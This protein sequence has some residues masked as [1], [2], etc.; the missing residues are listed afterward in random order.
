MTR[1]KHPFAYAVLSILLAGIWL[2]PVCFSQNYPAHPIQLV[3]PNVAGA[4]MDIAARLLAAEME[5]I[6]GTK[7]IPNN[8]PGAATVLGTDAVVRAKKDGYT[9]LFV[10]TSALVHAP[11]LNPEVVKYDPSK[12]LEPLGLYYFFPN[13]ITVKADSPWKTFRD[14]ADYAKKNP[15][16]I[17]VSTTGVG[18]G[19][20]IVVEMIQAITGIELTHVPFE[21]GESVVTAVLGGHVEATCD[22]VSKLKPHV[23]AGKLRFLLITNKMPILPD[24]PTMTELGY[25]QNLPTGWFALFAPAGIP[26][27]VKKVLVPAIEKAV[28]NTKAKI[29]EM[30]NLCDY[31]SPAELRKLR[32]EEYK[33]IYE[34]A[35]KLGLRKP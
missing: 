6:L 19:P 4:Q 13:T 26:E 31:K 14:L 18:S 22:N 34:I 23:D 27:E 7:I 33:Q 12:D 8:K 17:R 20:H 11:I 15:G 5:K 1:M 3:I 21:G 32:D 28:R 16:K 35:V 25:K 29:D 9:L 2:P 30:G 24:V 10:G